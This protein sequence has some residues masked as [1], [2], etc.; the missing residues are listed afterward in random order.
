MNRF[1]RTLRWFF[2]GLK[3]KDDDLDGLEPVPGYA[4]ILMVLFFPITISVWLA[5]EDF[6]RVRA[7]FFGED[8]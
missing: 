5:W 4:L 7:F 3:Q 2:V 8:D 6:P 1:Q